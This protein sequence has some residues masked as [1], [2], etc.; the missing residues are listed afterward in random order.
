MIDAALSSRLAASFSMGSVT[1]LQ[2]LHFPIHHM[3]PIFFLL[4]RQYIKW[5]FQNHFNLC[6][7]L[8]FCKP[9]LNCSLLLVWRGPMLCLFYNNPQGNCLLWWLIAPS[10]QSV[11]LHSLPFHPCIHSLFIFL[12]TPYWLTLRI[13]NVKGRHWL[14]VL[15]PFPQ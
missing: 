8:Y 15:A 13:W 10:K 7:Y 1:P 3:F 6:R 4:S 14:I 5:P 9:M 2:L 12:T 11:K